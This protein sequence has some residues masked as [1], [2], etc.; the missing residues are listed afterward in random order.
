MWRSFKHALFKHTTSA[1]EAWQIAGSRASSTA[2]LLVQ[3]DFFVF[4]SV[5]FSRFVACLAIVQVLCGLIHH[6]RDCHELLAQ[7]L[8][9]VS[10]CSP[11]VFHLHVVLSPRSWPWINSRQVFRNLCDGQKLSEVPECQ[12]HEE[13]HDTAEQVGSWASDLSTSATGACGPSTTSG[14]LFFLEDLG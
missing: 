3:L 9:W 12:L 7:S 10:R 5:S 1:R 14:S 13:F 4:V 2:P 6:V 8:S 11:W